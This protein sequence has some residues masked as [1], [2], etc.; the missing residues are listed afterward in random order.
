MPDDDLIRMNREFD[1]SGRRI[2][3][4]METMPRSHRRNELLDREGARQESLQRE[5]REAAE[6]ILK[7]GI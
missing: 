3:R 2:Q 1:D 6:D 5:K 7:R 4:T